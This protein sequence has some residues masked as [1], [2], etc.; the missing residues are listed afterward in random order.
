MKREVS[1]RDFSEAPEYFTSQRE[2]G[3]SFLRQKKDAYTAN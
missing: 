2:V 3:K 1:V